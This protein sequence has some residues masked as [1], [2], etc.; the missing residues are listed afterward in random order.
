MSFIKSVVEIHIH[1]YIRGD[2]C[3]VILFKAGTETNS[4]TMVCSW[5]EKSY[6][7]SSREVEFEMREGG[8]GGGNSNVNT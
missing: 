6:F 3:Y 2:R 4:R 8:G 5:K 7:Y 1:G